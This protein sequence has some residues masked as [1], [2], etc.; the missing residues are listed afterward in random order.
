MH[1]QFGTLTLRNI[2]M[3]VRWSNDRQLGMPATDTII[4]AAS[5]ISS[6]LSPGLHYKN[7]NSKQNLYVLQDCSPYRYSSYNY[8]NT[9]RLKNHTIPSF[10]IQ[11]SSCIQRS[12]QILIL[13]EHN[14]LLEFT[15]SKYNSMPNSQHM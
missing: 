5:H 9:N 10:Y 14:H 4:L 15:T 2:A 3:K 1:A 8:I 6:K 11:T 13:S 12:V 7:V